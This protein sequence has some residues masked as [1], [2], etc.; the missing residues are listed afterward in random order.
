MNNRLLGVIGIIT[1]PFLCLDI[2][3]NGNNGINIIQ[4]TSLSGAY[5]FVFFTGC[6]CSITGVRA[7]E[8]GGTS[9]WAR[10]TLTV[11]LLCLFIASLCSVYEVVSPGTDSALYFILEKFRPISHVMM[12][13]TGF[14]ILAANRLPGWKR[15]IPLL[16]G[17]WLPVTLVILVFE[18]KSSISTIVPALYSG[19]VWVMLGFVVATT[20]GKC[21]LIK[22]RVVASKPYL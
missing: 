18:G 11:Q 8:A 22:S 20:T 13:A 19:F 4:H 12:L 9:K 6:F 3:I 2:I 10:A 7:I 5:N 16:A 1:A 21:Y 14:T 17:L 15:Y